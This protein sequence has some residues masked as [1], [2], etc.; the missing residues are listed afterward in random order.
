MKTLDQS[1][2]LG[3]ID[4]GYD[5]VVGI[6]E[7]GRGCFAGPLYICAFLYFPG[8]DKIEGVNDS[9]LL[10]K[11]KREDVAL[12]LLAN[13]YYLQKLESTFLDKVGLSQAMH[14]GLEQLIEKVR[15][16][17]KDQKI[18]FLIDGYF[19]GEW[20]EDVVFIPKGDS[21]VYSIAAASI[22]AKVERDSW[23]RKIAIKYPGYDFDNNVGYGTLKHRQAIKRLGICDIHRRSFAPIKAF[24]QQAI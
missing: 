13:K 6:D 20:G 1:Y 19:K 11:I 17:Y 14:F 12:Q 7:V 5:I 15:L 3:Y 10:S 16:E 24:S 18:V 4:S 9:K 2:E 21:K 23:M 8:D 22:L